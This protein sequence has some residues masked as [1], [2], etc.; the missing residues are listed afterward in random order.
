MSELVL[1]VRRRGV[2]LVAMSAL[3]ALR[4]PC[5]LGDRLVALCRDDGYVLGLSG[6]FDAAAW[7]RA[8]VARADWFNP[9]KHRYALYEGQPGAL[10]AARGV[11]AWP[12]P[13]LTRRLGSDRPDL[14]ATAGRDEL[15]AWLALPAQ[16][17]TTRHSLL[18]WQCDDA[19]AALPHGHWPDAATGL[20][21]LTL[22]TLQLRAGSP[23]D[24]ARLAEEAAITRTRERGLLVHPH[25]QGWVWLQAA[26]SVPREALR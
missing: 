25:M 11:A 20:V 13:W 21:R 9:N 15:E 24:A 7:E 4:G 2:D 1:L 23:D 5:G 26:P 12:S 16:P 14:A 19:V 10:D 22:W 8:C 18:A 3:T 6:A 17:S